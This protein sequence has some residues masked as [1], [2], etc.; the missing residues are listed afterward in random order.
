MRTPYFSDS[1]GK[2][3]LFLTRVVFNLETLECTCEDL[4][5]VSQYEFTSRLPLVTPLFNGHKDLPAL[6]DFNNRNQKTVD[7]LANGPI[8]YATRDGYYVD[9]SEKYYMREYAVVHAI[10]TQNNEKV[11]NLRPETHVSKE[12][13]LF[14]VNILSERL[15]QISEVF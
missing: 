8:A 6:S 2:H 3:V 5:R 4:F 1:C 9:I 15:V 11:Q 7:L 14:L 10:F 12:R 13:L